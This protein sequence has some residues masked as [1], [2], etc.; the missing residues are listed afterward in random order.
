[1]SKYSAGIYLCKLLYHGENYTGKVE[2]YS[3]NQAKY[4]FREQCGLHMEDDVCLKVIRIGDTEE[5]KLYP[6]DLD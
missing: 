5:A 2:A 4:R 3:E 1:M 6:R